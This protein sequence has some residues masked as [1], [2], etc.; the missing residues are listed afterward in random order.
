M[1][2]AKYL[3]LV[4]R[5]KVAVD[6]VLNNFTTAQFNHLCYL[7]LIIILDYFSNYYFDNVPSL[8]LGSRV[9]SSGALLRPKLFLSGEAIKISDN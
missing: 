5:E 6:Y 8:R 1:L 2:T 9:L 3:Y 4:G 7:I